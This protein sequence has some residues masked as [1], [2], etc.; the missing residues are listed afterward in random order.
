MPKTKNALIRQQVIDRCL[1]SVAKYTI[2]DIMSKCNE[3]LAAEGESAVTS[4]VTILSDIEQIQRS[5]PD[6]VVVSHRE[7]RKIYYEY[8]NKHFSIYNLPL[9]EDEMANLAQTLSILSKFDGMPQFEW[10]DDLLDRF[11][12]S[13]RIP[14]IRNNFVS[15][16]ENF[17]L[18]GRN[19][20]APIFNAIA[21][22]NS[23]D[24]TYTTFSGK[25]FSYLFH[26]HFLKQYN[27]RWFVFGFVGE[28]N[29]ETSIPLDR[30]DKLEIS[31]TPYHHHP[32]LDFNEYFEDFVGATKSNGEPQAVQLF[33]D[34]KTYPYIATKP[35]HGTQKV[36]SHE[37]NGTVVSI[38]VIPNFE[39]EQLILSYGEAIRVISPET[40]ANKIRDRIIAMA[41]NIGIVQKD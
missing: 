19:Y 23:L 13:M 25:T 41:K 2:H 38:E 15:F 18:K 16:D 8:E 7:G 5:F 9:S 14:A 30:I 1:G 35:L 6:A 34:K 22:Q 26:P 32:E 17:D 12:A 3:A 40:L 39:L 36:I 10:I 24:I 20:F 21:S 27:K 11:S 33:V 31:A 29:K 4:K 28:S 37:E